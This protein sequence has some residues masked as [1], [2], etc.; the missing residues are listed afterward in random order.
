MGKNKG[1]NK[2]KNKQKQINSQLEKRKETAKPKVS[3]L[4]FEEKQ[5]SKQ[6]KTYSFYFF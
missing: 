1:K 6:K 3:E 2:Q 5:N 4:Q